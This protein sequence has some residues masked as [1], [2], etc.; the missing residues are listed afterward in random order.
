M[1]PTRVFADTYYPLYEKATGTKPKLTSR[2]WFFVKRWYE[3]NFYECVDVMEAVIRRYF[4]SELGPKGNYSLPFLMHKGVT[5]QLL[6]EVRDS[7]KR[8]RNWEQGN[9][10]KEEPRIV[11][12]EDQELNAMMER[13]QKQAPGL[14]Y[15]VYL[16]MAKKRLNHE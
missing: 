2:D 13:L 16:A 5:L 3:K 6:D 14:G 10:T 15:E 1:S 11:D 7:M 12:A 9:Y 4:G 8:A